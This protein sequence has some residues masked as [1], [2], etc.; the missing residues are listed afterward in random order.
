MAL[1]KNLDLKAQRIGPQLVDYQLAQARAAFNPQLTGSYG[2]NNA[3]SP[4]NSNLEN[5]SNL[6]NV[7]QSFNTGMTQQMRWFGGQANLSFTNSRQVTNA[8]TTQRNPSFSSGFSATYSQPLLAGFK[9]DGTRNNLRT[10][11]ITRQISD[12]TLLAAVENMKASVRTAY[13]NLRQAIESI[14]IQRRALDL[15]RRLF[16][17][18]RIKYEI[19]TL[20]QIDTVQPE[21][22]VANSEVS[23][24]NAEITWRTNELNLKRLLA[25]AVG[26][27][28]YR[29][30]IN[31]TEQAVMSTPRI[32]I[33]GAVKRALADRTD[34]V[35]TRRN[36]ESAQLSLELT[37][38]STKPNLGLQGGYSLS[39]Q[40]GP[41]TVQGVRQPGGYGDAVGQVF[42]FDLPT[43]NLQLNF[44]YPLFMAAA[45]ANYARAVLQLEQQKVQLDS[46]RLTISADV[47]NAGLAV[48]N[49]F[50]Q[51][52]ASVKAREAAE[53]NA[54]A[55]QT[56]FDVGMSTNYNV[57]QAQ[58]N[59]T[60]QRLSELQRLIQY[61]NA[62]AEFDRI[63]RVGR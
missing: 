56:R 22:A 3:Q 34:V 55:E 53:K 9:I 6:T 19:G 40:G 7:R 2:Y 62:V 54:E 33:P 36:I 16:E 48:E 47:T 37:E 23:L 42:G 31:P 57:V 59:L 1:E 58:N 8:T 15:A 43:W 29:S 50:K 24:L 45:R 13:W 10:L 49:T 26:D 4:N 20:A 63:Q 18:N 28:I 5:V 38:N 21:T 46:T 12:L 44:T 61:L 32:D 52:Q 41:L 30:T 60:S 27:E 11:A 17:D 51:Y 35:T 25:G 39:G 14:E